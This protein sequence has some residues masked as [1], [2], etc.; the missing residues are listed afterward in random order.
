MDADAVLGQLR[1]QAPVPAIVLLAHKAV[2]GLGQLLALFH[3]RQPVGAGIHR[4]FFQMLQQPGNPYLKE[5]VQVARRDGQKLHPL[6]QRIA[7]VLRLFQHATVESQPAQA[8][9]QVVL[10]VGQ[11]TWRHSYSV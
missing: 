10:R 1:Q 6:Q 4:A 7:L 2:S 3:R 5:L 8:A 9:V 11:R